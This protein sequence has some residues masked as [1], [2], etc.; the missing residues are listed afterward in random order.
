MNMHTLTHTKKKNYRCFD[1]S[2]IFTWWFGYTSR[3]K[4]KMLLDDSNVGHT[5]TVFR[6]PFLWAMF[7]HNCLQNAL[8][9]L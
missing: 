8:I 7:L 4:I 5:A 3:I 6:T 9:L 1:F 2:S